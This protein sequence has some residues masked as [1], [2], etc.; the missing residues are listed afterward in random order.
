MSK[1]LARDDQQPSAPPPLEEPLARVVNIVRELLETAGAEA[2]AFIRE[3]PKALIA[4]PVVAR[5]LPVVSS[6]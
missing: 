3:W 6:L 2:E 4:R 1:S 5:S